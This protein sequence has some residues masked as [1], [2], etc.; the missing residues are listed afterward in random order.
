MTQI[1]ADNEKLSDIRKIT[2]FFLL[3][4]GP[5]EN[6]DNFYKECVRLSG[7]LKNIPK[8]LSAIDAE[9]IEIQLWLERDK[10]LLKII[11][12][13]SMGMEYFRR[14]KKIAEQITDGKIDIKP[15]QG[16]GIT[17]NDP[18]TV[19]CLFKHIPHHKTRNY[20][21]IMNLISGGIIYYNS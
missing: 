14:I 13:A 4:K 18:H 16:T 12:E 15:Y 10:F 7:S 1:D 19:V 3:E 6:I 20:K 5:I 8:H 11:N 21:K 9:T 2:R 17:C